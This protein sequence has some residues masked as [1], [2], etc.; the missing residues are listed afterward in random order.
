MKKLL[1]LLAV[2]ALGTQTS[3]A[4]K[5]NTPVKSEKGGIFRNKKNNKNQSN[6]ENEGSSTGWF[7]SSNE[8]NSKNTNTKGNKQKR[9]DN[10]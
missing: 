3:F 10:D 2:L 5:E 6:K 7:S 4:G 1:A 8:G 9:A